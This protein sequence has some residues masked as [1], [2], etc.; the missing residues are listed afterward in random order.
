[1]HLLTPP[2]ASRP[3]TTLVRTIMARQ[4]SKRRERLHAGD[5]AGRHLL[6]LAASAQG[7]AANEFRRVSFERVG[8][9]DHVDETEV[10]VAALNPTGVARVDP[11]AMRESLLAQAR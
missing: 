1:M 10:A 6:L 9:T 5:G 4:Q 11:S 7:D 8:D 3:P 2:P